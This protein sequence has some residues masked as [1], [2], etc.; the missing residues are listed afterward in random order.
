MMD[1][2]VWGAKDPYRQVVF[3]GTGTNWA[4]WTRPRGCSMVHIFCVGGGSGGGGAHT[5]ASGVARGGGGGGGGGAIVNLMGPL[6]L[7]P[8]RLYVNCGLGGAGGIATAAGAD[9]TRSFVSINKGS[10]TAADLVAQ[11]GAAAATGGALGDNTTG[12]A[13][14]AA[15]TIATSGSAILAGGFLWS[16]RVGTI[17][18]TG[19]AQTGGAGTAHTVLSVNQTSGGAGGGG[20]GTNDTDAAGGAITGAGLVPSIAG[21]LAAGGVGQGG[22]NQ[23]NPFLTTGGSGGGTNGASGTGGK[24][25]HG[26]YG[27]GGGGGGGG[28]TGGA[29]G[30]GG[31]GIVIITC[32]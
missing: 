9:A 5:A 13:A 23:L 16:A 18:A 3:R 26:G 24:G 15:E 28:T 11:S 32:W 25:G 17:G 31:P 2:G 8:D 7:L 14:G 20:V 27:S 12:G 21:G 10:T 4:T 6:I 22:W 1:F 19:G 29:G 30:R